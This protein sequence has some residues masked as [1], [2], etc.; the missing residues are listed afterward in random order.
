VHVPRNVVGPLR[1]IFDAWAEIED[2]TLDVDIVGHDPGDVVELG[3]T[4]RATCLRSVHRVPSLA[5]MI[6]RV[7]RRL[8]PEYAGQPGETLREL[9]RDGTEITE[10]HHE[11]VLA[12]TGDTRIELWHQQPELRRTKVLVYE[13]TAWDDRADVARTR[14]WGHTHVDEM[15]ACAEQ[16]EGEALVLVHRSPRHSRAQAEQIVREQ[17]PATVRDRVH[18]FG[19]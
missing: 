17:F 15:I 7:S 13:V 16:F 14:E 6:E 3:R 4:R 19:T 1:R 10:P 18:V 2:F 12:V 11:P 8:K 9:R 5:W